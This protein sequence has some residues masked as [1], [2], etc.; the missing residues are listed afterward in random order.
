MDGEEILGLI[1]MLSCSFGCGAL[2]FSLGIR[3]SKSE[4]SFGFWTWQE[5]KIESVRDVCAYNRENGIMWKLYSM[6]YFISCVL[7][8]A[9]IWVPFCQML[10]FIL[11]IAASTLGIGWLIW[12]YRGIYDKYTVK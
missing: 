3:A 8:I 4:K 12:R 11:L 10:S 6:P 7:Y 9:G 5:V 1:V 2:F